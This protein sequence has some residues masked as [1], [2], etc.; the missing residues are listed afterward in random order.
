M[1]GT[2][3]AMV[4]FGL[5]VLSSCSSSSGMFALTKLQ[6]RYCWPGDTPNTAACP[7]ACQNPKGAC[8]GGQLIKSNAFG[9][10]T[11]ETCA[12]TGGDTWDCTVGKPIPNYDQSKVLKVFKW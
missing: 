2:A 7:G 4:V 9:G 3:I 5:C 6:A 10:G 1:S 11:P 12:W 8:N